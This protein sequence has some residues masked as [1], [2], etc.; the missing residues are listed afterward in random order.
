MDISIDHLLEY[1]PF[2]QQ[3][4]APTTATLDTYCGKAC[5]GCTAKESLD[6]SG[7][8]QFSHSEI[9][10]CAIA[11]C[12]QDKHL[13]SCCNCGYHE[14]CNKLRHAAEVPQQRLQSLQRY[15]KNQ[16]AENAFQQAKQAWITTHAP[17]LSRWLSWMLVLSLLSDGLWILFIL[18]LAFRSFDFLPTARLPLAVLAPLSTALCASC[19]FFLVPACSTYRSAARSGLAATPFALFATLLTVHKPASLGFILP[20]LPAL[21][22]FLISQYSLAASQATVAE[23]VD[24]ML[25]R[26]WHKLRKWQ[27]GM[28]IAC[29]FFPFCGLFLL[30]IPILGYALYG[31][32]SPLLPCGSLAVELVRL[33]FLYRTAKLF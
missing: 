14:T 23:K 31:I 29:Y 24:P 12:C 18:T 13:A 19:A 17:Q 6:C 10:R 25:S 4:K 33:Y 3:V 9:S 27:V 8:K 16:Q 15:A 32:I 22:L 21:I 7:C 11:R 20:L 1:T 2:L 30:T 28:L 5:D 26:R